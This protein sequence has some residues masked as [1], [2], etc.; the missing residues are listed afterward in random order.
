MAIGEFQSNAELYSEYWTAFEAALDEQREEW[1]HDRCTRDYWMIFRLDR[2]GVHLAA[3]IKVPPRRPE[4]GLRVELSLVKKKLGPDAERLYEM[5]LER[6]KDWEAS[7]GIL[8]DWESHTA[9]QYQVAVNLDDCGPAKR[10]DWPRQ[11]AQ[12][13]HWL[14]QFNDVFGARR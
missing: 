2:P 9:N 10:D 6:K 4:R 1:M 8:L 5:L 14:R 7:V 3:V 12:L 11:H 13:L